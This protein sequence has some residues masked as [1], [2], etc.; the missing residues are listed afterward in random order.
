M[1]EVIFINYDRMPPRLDS[2]ARRQ[3]KVLRN[4]FS[5]TF[6]VAITGGVPRKNHHRSV[7]E[8]VKEPQL[9]GIRCFMLTT[10]WSAPEPWI[11]QSVE[12]IRRLSAWILRRATI[13][14]TCPQ[15]RR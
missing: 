15:N 14:K 13:P 3:V 5:S 12:R 1:R 9:G 10:E 11:Y 2:T 6:R 7:R 8:E 4:H